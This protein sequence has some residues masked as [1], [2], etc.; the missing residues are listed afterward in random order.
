MSPKP[1]KRDEEVRRKLWYRRLEV[2]KL[3]DLLRA[4]DYWALREFVSRHR[5]LLMSH[6]Q[7]FGFDI[8]DAR[9]VATEVLHDVARELI[10][11]RRVLPRSMDGYVVRCFRNRVLNV[12]RDTRRRSAGADISRTMRCEEIAAVRETAGCSEDMLQMAAG[13]EWEPAPLNPLLERLAGLLEHAL[14]DDERQLL[15]WASEYVPQSEIAAWLGINYA[16]ARKRLERLRERL[17]VAAR[18]HVG[19]LSGEER[20]ELMRFFRRVDWVIDADA[21]NDRRISSD[22]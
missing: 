13:P 9:A 2:G 17:A 22:A 20:I 18:A 12:V 1:G 6:A 8:D 3:V 21:G 4:G 15:S 5:G 19:S 10:E 11:G 14:S 16:A 7:R